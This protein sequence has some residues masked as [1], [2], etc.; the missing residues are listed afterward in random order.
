MRLLFTI[1]LF[2]FSSVIYSQDVNQKAGVEK[3]IYNHHQPVEWSSDN[4]LL[5]FEPIGPLYGIQ[6]S[7]GTIFVVVNDTSL[8]ANLGIIAFTSTDN[9]NSWTTYGQGINLRQ[10]FENIKLVK[11]GL[12]SIYCFFQVGTEV[13]N[14][15]I[16][17]NNVNVFPFAGYRAFDA[18]ASSSGAL[19]LFLDSL[20]NNS[21][22]RYSSINGGAN[23][24]PRGLISNDGAN[25]KTSMSGTG[26]TLILNYYGPVLA[27]TSTS[28][29][30]QARYRE[31]AP[32]TL[33]SAG[34]ID[35]ALD[36]APKTEYLSAMN[37]GESWFVY[38]SGAVGSR[39]IY[40]SKSTNGGLSY[41]PAVLLAGNVNTDEYWFDLKYFKDPGSDGGFDLLYYSDSAQTGAATLESDKLLYT[42][43]PYGSAAF[44]PVQRINDYPMVF[45]SN[46][47]IP[48]LIS[49]SV[50]ARDAFAVYIGETSG[51]KKLF[52]DNLSAVIPVELISFK[53][54][55]NG[56]SIQ[57][58]WSTATETNNYGFQIERQWMQDEKSDNWKT[59]GF[60]NGNGT[61]TEIK[62]YSYTDENLSAGKYQY[63]LKQID[64]DGSYEYSN[65]VEADITIPSV[66]TLEQ[67]YPN[68][69]NPST[70][71]SWQSP[72]GAWQ[73]MKIY[74]VLGNEI[75]TL[76]D[77]YREAGKYEIEF[78]ASELSSGVYFYRL[79]APG[80]N[81][82]HKMILTK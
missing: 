13:Y 4:L 41:N 56:N 29:I 70:R 11:S 58:E 52:V 33:G 66:Y 64:L 42:S 38:T 77:E 57:L 40:G 20:A 81:Q 14:W 45:S 47:Y 9:G 73:T 26:D 63:R 28:V 6:Q 37:N 22:L 72:V 71:I 46:N 80:F 53:A 74:D 17:T 48:K 60:V 32:G 18:V 27:D 44:S 24:G 55:V 21:L 31:L 12:D 61:T 25:P 78:N 2:L 19:Y 75:A 62:S 7:T 76:V 49:T 59:I 23:W 39:N 69:F 5:N 43:V 36:N 54:F 65:I 67:N 1:Y 3:P 8:T 30:R 16:L 79:I 82:V 50:P 10:K 34:F 35:V 15:N 51:G 68:P